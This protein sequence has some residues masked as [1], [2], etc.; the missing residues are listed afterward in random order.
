M[1]IFQ[2]TALP[3]AKHTAIATTHSQN[4]VPR[5][6]FS[7]S[8]TYDII[9]TAMPPTIVSTIAPVKNVITKYSNIDILY[10]K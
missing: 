8:T 3:I 2:E 7:S 6:A 9:H 1:R 5:T 10:T 4:D